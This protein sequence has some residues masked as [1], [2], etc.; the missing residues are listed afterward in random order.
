LLAARIWPHKLFTVLRAPADVLI[1]P[2]AVHQK[3][4]SW[5]PSQSSSS[6]VALLATAASVRIL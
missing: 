6:R 4:S 2:D 5:S 1:D 3:R